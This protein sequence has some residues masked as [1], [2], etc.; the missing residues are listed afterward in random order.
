MKIRHSLLLLSAI[1]VLFPALSIG[2][3]TYNQSIKMKFDGVREHHLLLAQTLSG[4]LERY[5]LDTKLMFDNI[6]DSLVSGNISKTST[7]VLAELDFL[8]IAI[9]DE[10]T[11]KIIQCIAVDKT[12]TPQFASLLVMKVATN[13]AKRDVTTFSP[14]IALRDGTNVMLI[15]RKIGDKLA[16]AKLKTDYITN[17]AEAIKFGKKGH[18]T[19]VDNEGNLLAH[20][21]KNWIKSRKN[22]ANIAPVKRMLNGETGITEYYSPVLKGNIIAGFAPV[23]GPGWGIMIPQPVVEFY[24]GSLNVWKSYLIIVV[25]SITVAMLIAFWM[26]MR[27]TQPLLNLISANKNMTNPNQR[28]I[29]DPPEN[30]AVPTEIKQLYFTHNEMISRLHSKHA[31]TM[32]MAYSD[33]VTGLP[34]RE[35]FN[36]LIENEFKNSRAENDSYLLIFLDL[37]EFKVI[38]DTMGHETGDTVLAMVARQIADSIT[39]YAKLDVITCPLD[40]FE[41]PVRNLDGRAVISR[42]GGDEFVALIPWHQGARGVESFLQSINEAVSSPYF[43][44]EKDLSTSTSIG[45]ALYG[46]HGFTIRELTKKADIAMYWAKKSGKNCFRLFDNSI[47][48]KTPAELQRDVA[49]AILNN[50]MKLY[51]QPKINNTTGEANSVE[52][53]VRWIHPQKGLISPDFFIPVINNTNVADSLGE[54]VIRAA[55]NQIREWNRVGKD[56]CVSINIANHH[57][58]S[59]NF[60]PNLLKI[61]DEIG[62]NPGSLE[63]EITEETAMTDHKRA[64]FAVR[65]LKEN[66]FAVSLDDYGKGYSNLARLAELDIDVIKLDLSLMNDITED[67]RRAIIVASALDMARNLNCETVAEGIETE[68]QAA[69]VSSMG[70]DYLQ[71]FLF[72]KPMPADELNI[73]L[74]KRAAGDYLQVDNVQPVRGILKTA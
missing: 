23:N 47:G 54:W 57:L 42:I 12:V 71:G 22:I 19:I 21:Q 49:T 65:A 1:L 56:I 27:S 37:D 64:K 7:A 31:D 18:A 2:A 68:E 35:A 69:F 51:Y 66:G 29:L 39:N 36:Q 67:P 58:V 16:I 9:V 17:L 53:L 33:M 10:A 34:T 25:T 28:K 73:W 48:D 45:A 41:N 61:V 24:A 59:Q 74:M 60:L 6:S 55:C 13:Y 26:S 38:N 8:D 14:V 62:I 4:T 40:E 43:I 5:Y 11:A 46:R 52:A 32:R 30:W 70:C 50:E 63:I 15:V 20:P 3:W 72:A 44:A